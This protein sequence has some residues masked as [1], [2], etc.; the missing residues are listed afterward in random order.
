MARVQH[1]RT[2][3]Y[4]SRCVKYSLFFFNFLFW[5]V[6]GCLVAIGGWSFLEEYNYK[7]LPA[8]NNAFEL[9][10][11][12][13]IIVM[14]L[15]GVVFIISFA[16]CLGALREN[17]C[18]LKF[19]S[20]ILLVLFLGEMALAI[21]AFVFP[22]QFIDIIQQ[23]LSKELTVKYRDDDNLQNVID[24][25]QKE[26]QCC[27]MS[28]KGYKDWSRNIY[29]NCSIHNKSPERCAVP[30]SC[31]RDPHNIDN[32]LVNMMC[33]YHM[34]N[35]SFVKDASD[36]IYTRGCIEAIQEYVQRNL[37][38]VAGIFLTVSFVQLFAM[39][40]CRTLLAQISMQRAQ[41]T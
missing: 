26:F 37:N 30:Y 6:S 9:F 34:Q 40:L 31:C 15:G 39:Y 17:R 1:R 11:R 29:F 10:V 22:N 20:Y 36:K 41:W 16:G 12:I 27:G 33:G 3:D 4:I 14:V 18:L 5:L 7:G 19:Y 8:I 25:F 23:G 38:L 35:S 2:A 13:S 21:F 28:D 32:G 24:G